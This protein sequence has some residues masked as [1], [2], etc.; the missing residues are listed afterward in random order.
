M[1]LT[2]TIPQQELFDEVKQEFV[3]V[4]E[5]TLTLEH[6]LLS[7]SKWESKW[8]KPYLDNANLTNEELLDYIRCM[9]IIPSHLSE[10]ILYGITQDNVQAIVNYIQN[11]MTATTF[12]ERA[13]KNKKTG[14]QEIV[15][16]ELIYYWMIAFQIP[17]KFEQWHLNRLLTL[18][19]ICQIENDPDKNKKK[20]LTKNDLMRRKEI[21]AARRAA[22]NSKG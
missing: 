2:I 3:N 13:D 17:V 6:S 22:L 12:N 7:I 18:V 20:K 11:P 15:T 9:V 19:K 4:P 1:P 21:N 16:S 8:H 10:E 14:K 5:T